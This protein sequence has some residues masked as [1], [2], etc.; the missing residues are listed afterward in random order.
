[1]YILSQSTGLKGARGGP[2]DAFRHTYASAFVSRH[3]SPSLVK[4]ATSLTERNPNSEHD[5]MDI[6]NNYLG[7]EIG[8]TDKPIYKTI[9]NE[10]KNPEIETKNPKKIHILNTS[11]WTSSDIF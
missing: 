1:M 5:Q 2:Q 4:I 8:L 9:L 3:L 11:K 7:I 10:L 6:H